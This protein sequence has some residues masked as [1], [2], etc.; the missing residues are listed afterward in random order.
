MERENHLGILCS[1]SKTYERSE[2]SKKGERR[3]GIGLHHLCK[4]ED[5]NA[6]AIALNDKLPS[7]RSAKKESGIEKDSS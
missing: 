2:L 4:G 1:D 6:A 5:L 7:T 3:G